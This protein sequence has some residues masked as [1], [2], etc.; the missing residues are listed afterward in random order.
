[1]RKGIFA[2]LFLILLALVLPKAVYASTHTLTVRS[3]SGGSVAIN[4]SSFGTS[5][6]EQVEAG[7]QVTIRA[8]PSST[9]FFDR[10]TATHG[11]IANQFRSETTFTMPARDI[12][13]WA[14]FIHEWDADWRWGGE[15]DS[16]WGWNDPRFGWGWHDSWDARWWD[17][18]WEEAMREAR[19]D[20]W[21]WDRNWA[22]PRWDW[23]FDDWRL[24]PQ[25][26]PF[27]PGVHSALPVPVASQPGTPRPVVGSQQN[28]AAGDTATYTFTMPGLPDGYYQI[29]ISNIPAGVATPG[30]VRVQNEETQLQITG[31]RNAAAGTHRLHL[32]LYDQNRRAVT[33]PTLFTLTTGGQ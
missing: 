27:P 19:P 21:R 31:I 16:R 7:A 32:R 1:M 25:F 5:R 23:R 6:T 13:V 14:D 30:F 20:D 18:R 4:N 22:D 11:T 24:N 12:T 29:S 3:H 28:D 15:F 17:W 9:H 33:V 10:W 8:R 26:S 2:A